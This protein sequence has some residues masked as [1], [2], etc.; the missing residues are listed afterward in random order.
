MH[1]TARSKVACSGEQLAVAGQHDAENIGH[2]A[3]HWHHFAGFTT[4]LVQVLL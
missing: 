2:T 3:L 4:V 1:C